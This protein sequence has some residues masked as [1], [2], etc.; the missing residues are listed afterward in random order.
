MNSVLI[1][2][3]QSSLKWQRRVIDVVPCKLC[4]ISNDFVCVFGGGGGGG[5]AHKPLLSTI[6]YRA[7]TTG[8][9]NWPKCL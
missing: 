8:E 3:V 7:K 5:G 9:G 1:K 6:T 2:G 4:I